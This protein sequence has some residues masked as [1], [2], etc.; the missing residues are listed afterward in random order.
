MLPATTNATYVERVVEERIFETYDITKPKQR[1]FVTMAVKKCVRKR[2]A[3]STTAESSLS[4]GTA[5][6]EAANR[7]HDNA[8]I[9]E[10]VQDPLKVIPSGSENYPRSPSSTVAGF[11][12]EDNTGYASSCILLDEVSCD[13]ILKQRKNLVLTI[14]HQKEAMKALLALEGEAWQQ[15]KT[16]QEA[17]HLLQVKHW[18]HNKRQQEAELEQRHKIKMQQQKMQVEAEAEAERLQHRTASI[19]LDR[20]RHDGMRN[21]EALLE[22]VGAFPQIRNY[23]ESRIVCELQWLIRELIDTGI[24]TD[25]KYLQLSMDMSKQ[26][27]RKTLLRLV[28]DEDEGVDNPVI[29]RV[30]P[31]E[32]L[33]I[34]TQM[35]KRV[36]FEVGDIYYSVY[37]VLQQHGGA[38]PVPLFCRL[39]CLSDCSRHA[40]RS[41]S[42]QARCMQIAQRLIDCARRNQNVRSMLENSNITQSVTGIFASCA[43]WVGTSMQRSTARGGI[44]VDVRNNPV[45]IGW[46]GD[47]DALFLFVLRHLMVC[48]K[49]EFID[50]VSP[51]YYMSNLP[52]RIHANTMRE[53]FD[54]AQSCVRENMIRGVACSI[55]GIPRLESQVVYLYPPSFQT[56]GLQLQMWQRGIAMREGYNHHLPWALGYVNRGTVVSAPEAGLS[57]LSLQAFGVRVFP[58][59]QAYNEPTRNG[60]YLSRKIHNGYGIISVDPSGGSSMAFVHRRFS[61]TPATN[62]EPL[63]IDM[64]LPAG[65]C[66]IPED[67]GTIQEL[68]C[69]VTSSSTVA[70]EGCEAL[71]AVHNRMPCAAYFRLDYFDMCAGPWRVHPQHTPTRQMLE[72][73]TDFLALGRDYRADA[74]SL[75][76]A[77]PPQNASV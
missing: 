2:F 3:I 67:I 51:L 1:M 56:Q 21:R 52:D 19:F 34:A 71:Q 65:T 70:V 55:H 36:T 32:S 69:A 62:D 29:K 39:V 18:E 35:F 61:E 33:D 60:W 74:S 23:K 43:L 37:V 53:F 6:G 4:T 42:P 46:Q 72:A 11:S 25:T 10:V 66:N 17:E 54:H 7:P 76:S 68:M 49:G 22:I 8:T 59:R 75:S 77:P 31:N 20:M 40:K 27:W 15:R 57:H 26:T 48:N 12:G 63:L 45:V 30:R 38:D 9:I 5:P 16:Q 41:K 50:Y 13:R 44:T 24:L 73:L 64:V 58:D 14:G 47:A 28:L